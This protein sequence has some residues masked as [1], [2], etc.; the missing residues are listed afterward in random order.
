[1]NNR[2]DNR[3]SKNYRIFLIITLHLLL[4]LLTVKKFVKMK[5]VVQRIVLNN[6]WT[7]L[8]QEVTNRSNVS[9]LKIFAIFIKIL[10]IKFQL[11][12]STP[13]NSFSKCSLHSFFQ[14]RAQTRKLYKKKEK[15][16]RGRSRVV[17]VKLSISSCSFKYVHG[18]KE[19]SMRVL[20]STANSLKGQIYNLAGLNWTGHINC[21]CMTSLMHVHI[22]SL[23]A[24]IMISCG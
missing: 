15:S 16:V 6:S 7:I 23:A 10:F 12:Y 17:K 13:Q 18:S 4:I 14:Q 8:F 2:W 9:W 1:M 21:K 19:E 3:V 20:N 24:R 22:L 11:P 5:I